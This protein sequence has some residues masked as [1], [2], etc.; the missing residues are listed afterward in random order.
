MS[1]RITIRVTPAL[2]RQVAAVAGHANTNISDACR[3]LIERGLTAGAIAAR[4]ADPAELLEAVAGIAA[5]VAE[6]QAQQEATAERLQ[7][8][9]SAVAAINSTLR[10]LTT[11]VQ[12]L[13]QPAAQAPVTRVEGL[14]GDERIPVAQ[15]VPVFAVWAAEKPWQGSED[16]QGRIARLRTEY[17]KTFGVAP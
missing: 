5:T 16:R 4:A 7:S 13:Y 2:H 14:P 15:S 17:S 10:D 12:R 11:A 6:H 3:L 9:G 8:L 1:N